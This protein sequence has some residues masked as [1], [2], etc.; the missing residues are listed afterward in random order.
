MALSTAGSA[1]SV[2]FS[3]ANGLEQD[4]AAGLNPAIHTPMTSPVAAAA[5]PGT[6]LPPPQQW[7]LGEYTAA[8]ML[9][10]SPANNLA[11][12]Q[13]AASAAALN[14]TYYAHLPNPLWYNNQAAAANH[15]AM[16]PILQQY[17]INTLLLQQNQ[18][19]QQQLL[20]AAARQQGISAGA[21]NHA[22]QHSLQSPPMTAVTLNPMTS[23]SM[24]TAAQ[25]G[26]TTTATS[27]ASTPT[28]THVANANL[29]FTTQ[30]PPPPLAAA[31]NPAVR[32]PDFILRASATSAL[33]MDA[34]TAAAVAAASAVPPNVTL[35]P[36]QRQE[37]DALLAHFQSSPSSPPR[38]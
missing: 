25:P 36:T 20:Q 33:S 30:T 6:T 23:L 35:T 16:H 31:L 3:M 34:V 21:V 12:H 17:Q 14:N 37:L 8:R 2:P 19:Q 11:A 9:G 32:F 15:A 27:M 13:A 26:G 38:T 24:A 7:P 29:P 18:L 10:Q 22:P 5:P 1:F 28:L 4:R